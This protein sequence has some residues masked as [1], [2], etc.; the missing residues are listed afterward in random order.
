MA[1]WHR[2]RRGAGNTARAYAGSPPGGAGRYPYSVNND[3]SPTSDDTARAPARVEVVERDRSSSRP[4]L[5]PAQAM[6]LIRILTVAAFIVILNETTM[7][8]AIA[9]L[10]REFH[11][12][13]SSAQWL[14]TAFMLTMAV[15]IPLTGWFIDRFGP[16]VSL[17][18]AMSTFIVGAAIAAFAPSFG[19]LLGA[20]VVQALGT[21]VMIPLLM[22]T[23][24]NVI[25]ESDRGRV[26]GSVS[27]A[28]S[29][30]PAIGPFLA[31][32]ILKYLGWRWI[33]GIVLP[34]AVLVTLAAVRLIPRG[35]GAARENVDALSVPLSVLGFGGIVWGLSS[36]GEAAAPPV[37][38][39]ALLLIGVVA[40]GAMVLRQLQLRRSWHEPLL[41]VTAFAHR[42]FAVGV[43]LMTIGFAAF[44]GI[45][46]ILPLLM[47]VANGDSAEAAGRALMPAGLMMGLLGPV[48][49]RY[50]DRHGARI[51]V[52]PGAVISVLALAAQA[53]WAPGGSWWLIGLINIV[54]G[55]GLAMTFTPMF[56]ASLSALPAPLYSH[57]SALLATL[58]QVGGAAGIAVLISLMTAGAEAHGGAAPDPEFGGQLALFGAAGFMV[59]VVLLAFFVPKGRPAASAHAGGGH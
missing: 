42:D 34:L 31:G 46:M 15:A 10:M 3:S 33:F 56:T 37:P 49:G 5:S 40:L 51:I 54:A 39:W 18:T 38:A 35:G 11:V 58:Q 17:L 45:M 50:Y 13:E 41:D 29:V 32:E 23:L 16:R 59:V 52:V 36:L 24:M 30:A 9:T 26:M 47:Q 44:L 28:I 7:T 1:T 19:V 14:T 12:V 6:L 48:V 8:P 43:S 55:T 22:T 25:P 21:A 2:W 53:V 4:D 20:R 27:L 57:G